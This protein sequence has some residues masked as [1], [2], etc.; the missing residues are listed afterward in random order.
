[1]AGE[2]SITGLGGTFDYSSILQQMQALKSQQIY[3]AQ[4]NQQKLQDKK[5]VISEI[6][7]ILKNI[8]NDVSKFTDLNT[9]NAKTAIVSDSSI[10]SVN[11]TDP[12]KAQPG[13]YDI[14]VVQLA[15]A[16]FYAS[17]NS[18]SNKDT[19]IPGLGSG[20]LKITYKGSD[21]NIVYDST[22]SLQAVADEINKV[23][24]TH[25]GDFRAS[26]VNIGTATNPQYKLVIVGTKTGA[27]NAIIINSDSGG[28]LNILG[29]MQHLRQA[30]NA[31][32]QINGLQVDSSTNQF[33][34]V[35]EGVSFTATKVGS[36]TLEIKQDTKPLKDTLA[37]FVNQYNS[38]VDKLNTETGKNGRLSGEYSLNQ[39]KN[40][41]LNSLTDLLVGGVLS[42]DRTTGH[43]SLNSSVLDNKLSTNPSDITSK[44]SNVKNSLY[45]YLL[46]TTTAGGPLDNM[47]KSYDKQIS[48]LQSYIDQMTAR[49]NQEIETLKNQFI[50]M[51]NLQAQ[52]NSLST[53]IQQTFGLNNKQ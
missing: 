45:N 16:D 14:N 1:M 13:V 28:L 21:Y 32:I 10:L 34:D 17:N 12:L 38:L 6:N 48:S 41:I 40:S 25:N 15:Q 30:Q 44:L 4:A 43:I 53:R 2:F 18:F 23:A 19:S 9:L 37:D 29:G 49:V 11:I 52:Y 27:E 22:Y 33:N 51:T 39:I 24:Q 7:N 20:T 3:M 5:N 35:L 50:Y 47:I 46:Q 26:I 42:F 36:A 31:T 8:L